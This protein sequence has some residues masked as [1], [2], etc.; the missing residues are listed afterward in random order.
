LWLTGGSHF[1]FATENGQLDALTRSRVGS[2]EDLAT[3]SESAELSDGTKVEVVAYED[4]VRAKRAAGR[5]QDLVDIE[6]LRE[7]RDERSPGQS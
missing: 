5:P 6:A 2:Y 3:R 7:L 1:V 4:L